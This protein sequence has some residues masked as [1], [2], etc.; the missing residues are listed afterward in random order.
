M[1]KNHDKNNILYYSNISS[2]IAKLHSQVKEAQ[3]Q[4]NGSTSVSAITHLATD[5]D[6]PLLRYRASNVMKKLNLVSC[7]LLQHAYK[8]VV[9]RMSISQ[10]FGQATVGLI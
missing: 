5:N 7:Q 2:E 10:T 6:Y 3:R 1:V 8:K 4:S 9:K